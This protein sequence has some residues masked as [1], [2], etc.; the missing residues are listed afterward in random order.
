MFQVYFPLK[1]HCKVI[2]VIIPVLH[3]SLDLGEIKKDEL[4]GPEALLQPGNV[5]FLL[6]EIKTCALSEN[7]TVSVIESYGKIQLLLVHRGFE[8]IL[9]R[10]LLS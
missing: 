10:N 7:H 1:F 3:F 4:P 5:N 2:I 9:R 6:I 8:S